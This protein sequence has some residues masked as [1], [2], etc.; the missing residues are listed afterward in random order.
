[1]KKCTL[2]RTL[3]WLTVATAAAGATTA[4]SSATS[5]QEGTDD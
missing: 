2:G 5:D 1:M 3:G 4:P